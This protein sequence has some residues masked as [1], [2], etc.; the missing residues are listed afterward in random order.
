MADVTAIEEAK[1]GD[2][3]TL[4]GTGKDGGPTADDIAAWCRTINYEVTC[5]IG[6]RVARVYL[7]DG[8]IVNARTLTE[9]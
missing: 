2:E 7:K 6:K 8:Q 1:R 5:L 9:L 4:F 3:V